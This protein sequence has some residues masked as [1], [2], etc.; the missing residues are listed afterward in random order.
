MGQVPENV[1]VTDYV[2]QYSGTLV[3]GE[4]YIRVIFICPAKASLAR[5][6]FR[7]SGGALC[8]VRATY[9]VGLGRLVGWRVGSKR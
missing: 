8:F 9:D 5:E 1:D 3:E 7:V 4:H 2:R 6:F